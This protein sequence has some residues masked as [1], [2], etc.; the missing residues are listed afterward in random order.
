MQYACFSYTY[1]IYILFYCIACVLLPSFCFVEFLSPCPVSVASFWEALAYLAN[2]LIF[3][4]VGMIVM[5]LMRQKAQIWDFVFNFL[6]YVSINSIRWFTPLESKYAILWTLR[7]LPWPPEFRLFSTVISF[8]SACSTFTRRT[9]N[10][11]WP[12]RKK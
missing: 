6:I 4:L 9:L 3:F 7:T 8:F 10:I 1:Y 11:T 12:I 5:Q 2:T